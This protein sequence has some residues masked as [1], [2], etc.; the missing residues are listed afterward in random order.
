MANV[1]LQ[2]ILSF[3]SS[4]KLFPKFVIKNWTTFDIYGKIYGKTFDKNMILYFYC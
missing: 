4:P 1:D 2:V 3:N